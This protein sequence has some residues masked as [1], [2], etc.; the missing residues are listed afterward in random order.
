MPK[1]AWREQ[2]VQDN[3]GC[4]GGSYMAI[5][6]SSV[7]SQAIMV[8]GGSAVADQ[9]GGGTIIVYSGTPPT[10]ANEGLSGN[11]VLATWT[12]AGSSSQISTSGVIA[13]AFASGITT[14]AA[15]ASGTA[16]FFRILNST[17][18]ALIQGSVGTSGAD[19]NLSSVVV[20]TGDNVSITGTPSIT[21][22]VI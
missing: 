6:L 19:F 5:T 2:V 11:T 21:M 7:F 9:V 12:L 10:G 14:V 3:L 8:H 13:L 20:T 17:P 15:A 22:P 16:T 1:Y 4:E 18:A